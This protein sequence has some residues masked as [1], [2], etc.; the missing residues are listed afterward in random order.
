MDTIR[1]ERVTHKAAEPNTES[2]TA[3]RSEAIVTKLCGRGEARFYVN[4]TAHT[5]SLGTNW[6]EPERAPHIYSI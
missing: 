4:D 5:I 6:S 1:T 3:P 2:T